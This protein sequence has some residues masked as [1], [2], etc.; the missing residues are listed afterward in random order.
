MFKELAFTPRTSH[1]Y[2][3]VYALD[4]CPPR[5]KVLNLIKELIESQLGTHMRRFGIFDSNLF[6]CV[7]SR[8]ESDIK[9]TLGP[10]IFRFVSLHNE[11]ERLNE[12][13]KSLIYKNLENEWDAN[14][15]QRVIDILA[16]DPMGE[17]GEISGGTIF[18]AARQ[19]VF[20]A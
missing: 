17:T 14:D 12:H 2:L 19:Q 18:V 1:V 11:R 20:E 10:L 15:M 16:E 6:I 9:S 4:E 8:L 5:A 3:I 13:I 7:T